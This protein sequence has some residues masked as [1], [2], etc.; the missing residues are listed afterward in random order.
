M[1]ENIKTL[2]LLNPLARF[3]KISLIIGLILLLPS[4]NL[5]P[6]SAQSSTQPSPNVFSFNGGSSNVTSPTSTPTPVTSGSLNPGFAQGQSYA[7]P[8]P[9]YA[10]SI[11]VPSMGNESS[12]PGAVNPSLNGLPPT[13]LD[14]FVYNAGANAFNIYGDEGT[15]I[16]AGQVG[17]GGS[18]SAVAPDPGILTGISSAP[19]PLGNTPNDTTSV[20]YGGF[21]ENMRINVGITSSASN[22]GL[23]T[24]HSSY[25][26]SAWGAD[27]F[28]FPGGEWNQAV[29]GPSG[30]AYNNPLTAAALMVPL[31]DPINY[32]AE[33]LAGPLL[34]SF[35]ASSAAS[36]MYGLLP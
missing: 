14:S 9:M 30:N 10:P 33:V 34:N 3:Q 1:N 31:A 21:T 28:L 17:P 22:N 13:T 24:G 18:Y 2:A 11:P 12:F 32:R 19:T 25:L 35:G 36:T 8:L 23:T 6:C 16:F 27:E 26:P 5:Q 20:N 7:P 4:T 29:L 15:G